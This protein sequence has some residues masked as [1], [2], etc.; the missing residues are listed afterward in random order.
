M[1]EAG[2]LP[3][4]VGRAAERDALD[5]ALARL[6]AGTGGVVVVEGEPGIGKSRLLAELAA[7]AEAAGCRVA[8]G[9]ASELETDLPYA[10][11]ADALDPLLQALGERAVGRLGLAD[12]A[13]LA[14]VLP[15]LGDP[16][17]P[18]RHRL[19]RA[20][21]DLLERAAATR[22]LVLCLDDVQWA[23][24]GS[25]DALA[26]LARRPPAGAVLLALA[27]REGALPGA[28]A[29]S[30]AAAMREDRVTRLALLPLA[31]DEAAALVG[32]DVT[33]LYAVSG[34]NPFYLEQLAR[35]GGAA[36]SAG[37]EGDPPAPGAIPPAVALALAAELAGV[38]PAAH[39]LLDA[40]A[41]T[42]DPFEPGLAA[43]VAELPE[44]A[45]LEA[46][47]EL[48]ART[49]V[50]PAGAAR[51]FA[52]RHP[53][54]RHAV[55]DAIPAGRR[56][57]AHARA[58]A[59]LERR[60]AGIVAR[61][62]HLEHAAVPG[63]AAA[64]DLL[65][66]AAAELQGPA[67]ASSARFHA[68]AL[69]ILPEDSGRRTTLEVALAE[70]QSAAGDPAAARETLLAALARAPAPERRAL[71]VRVANVESWLGR[72]ED[73]R[74]RLYL[75]L[76]DLAAEPS[77][78]R[79]RLQFAL[80]LNALLACD[81]ADSRARAADALA[82]TRALG[83]PVLEASALAL[84]ALAAAADPAGAA[85]VAAVD[86][87]AAALER[88]DDAQLATRLPALWM[89][90]CAEGMLGRF[91]AALRAL[92]RAAAAAEAS[93][94][95]S[96][97]LL[98]SAEAMRPLRELGRVP[99]AVASGEQAADR[100]RLSG[101]PQ[102]LLW[103]Q[104]ALA[105]AR[106]AA[107][108]VPGALRE[109][110][111][112]A[113]GADPHAGFHRAGQPGWCLGTALTAAGNAGRAVPLMR[114]A[115]GPGLAG[116]VPALRPA[117]AADLIE[118]QLAAGDVAGARET[119]GSARAA[120]RRAATPWAAA[121]AG[122]AAAA[123]LLAEGRADEAAAEAGAAGQ[124]ATGAPLLASRARLL[125]GRALAAAGDRPAALE[126]LAGAESA[127][128]A[129]GARRRHAEA[130]RELRRLGRRVRRPAEDAAPDALGPLTA[131]ERE[132][133]G[134]VAA[135]HTNREVAE[136]LVLS[137]KTIEA[138]LRNIYAKLGVRS[139]VELARRAGPR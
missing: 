4:L 7:R 53:V 93:G 39:R 117:A 50:R 109:A 36:P 77:G 115:F 136:Q 130:T 23:D 51:R 5:A 61:A 40:A 126:A 80:G 6:R 24:P 41:V 90:A 26:A 12:P 57:A 107:G 73:V 30:L 75:A 34:G 49:L 52:F 110:E 60:G 18:D 9:W 82:D 87:A 131:R 76:G 134:L 38:P 71:T 112:A 92:E 137:P 70:A 56:L 78:D 120:A 46:L 96:V 3:P 116:V 14:A 100:A 17:P 122:S 10:V 91:D 54:V 85:T 37:G 113:E 16:A 84:G 102:L 28:L 138:H 97:L 62:H 68:A 20:L 101:N 135:G 88:L 15:T 45:A 48:L 94:R 2:T 129:A 65:A 114:D 98:V 33:G 1:V 72:D 13:A 89:L 42:G 132:I 32:G 139:R 59:A 27:V 105:G 127:L 118:A 119:L 19:H 44:A 31:E 66:A 128:G 111:D 35:S 58:A 11:L 25:L 21:R 86:A 22:P 8:S 133:A 125:E 104:S 83:D 103:A 99:D 74:R 124:V 95:E 121:V 106:L 108:D 64:T 123:V 67:P 69:R 47:D 79:I 81:F 55:Y 63:D 43:D 29:A